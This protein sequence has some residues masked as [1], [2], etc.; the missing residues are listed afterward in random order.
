MKPL[1][2]DSSSFI[3][4][5]VGLSEIDQ[6]TIL[7]SLGHSDIHEF[8][9][10]V[11][12]ENILDGNSPSLSF[13]K[14]CSEI[15]ALE[16]ISLIAKKNKVF[17]SLI[18]LGYY[19][20]S[21]P[22]SVQRHV[23][24]NPSWYTA[25]TPYQAEI[26][27][28]RLE[29][30]FNFQTLISELTGLPIANASLL[31]EA[32]AAAE[33]MS[34]SFA[35]KKNKHARKFLVD[36]QIFPQTFSVLKTRAQ[37]LS[38][39]L[40]L[41]NSKDL[42]L[43]LDQDVF[44]ILLQLPGTNGCIWNPT[45]CIAKAHHFSALATIIIDPLAQVLLAP[46][47]EF[48]ADIAVGSAQRLGVPVGFGGPHAAFFA[49]KE[50][51]KRQVP[52]RLVGESLD[53]DGQPALRLALQ[54]REQHIRRDKATSNICTAQVLLA[55]LS[56]FFAIYHGSKGLENIAKKIFY[57]KNKLEH[58]LIELGY[59]V[60]PMDRFDTIEVLCD[61]AQEVHRLSQLEGFN[62]RILKSNELTNQINGFGITIDELSN[63]NEL[64]K[65][66][67]ILSK[68]KG[69]LYTNSDNYKFEK[70]NILNSIPLRNKPWLQQAVFNQYQSE[71]ELLRYIYRLI[72]KDF[73]LVNGMIPLG[74]CTMKLNATAELLPISWKEFYSIHPFAPESQTQGYKKL[75]TDLEQWLSDL[76]GFAASSL[77]PNAGSQGEFAGLL[78]IQAWHQS[79]GD[80]D[81]NVCLIP[82]SAHGTNPASAVMAGL[83]V[84]PVSCDEL[85]NIDFDDLAQKCQE[86]SDQLSS[87][88]VT[89]PSTHGVFEP[90]IREICKIVHKYGGQVY[91]DGANLNA[92]V[93]LCRPGKYGADVCHLNLHKTFC[94][95]HGGGGPGI[96]PIAVASHLAPF[97]PGHPLVDCGGK[98]AIGPVSSAPFGSASILPISW[99]YIRMMGPENLR[100]ASASAMLSA[101]F[102]ANR[103]SDYYPVLFK[104][105]NGFVAH[106]CILD[107]RPIK[108]SSGIEVDDI[109]KRLM[110]YGFHA[111]TVSWPV[112][113]TLMVEPTESESLNELNRFC[114][115][116]IAIRSE[117]E[118][119]EMGSSDI[120]NNPLRSAPHTL[121]VVTADKWDRPYSRT[122]AA[123]PL[124]HQRKNK[125]WPAVAR[126]DNAF[127]DRNLVCTC[128][129]LED[130]TQ[131]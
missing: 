97:L 105:I 46:V 22:A 90:Q 115:A 108:R 129:S 112:A 27:Q 66:K 78:V 7:Q 65:I 71:T 42:A 41:V 3:S 77:Q 9:A 94:I 56:A 13:E 62:F 79:R 5:H 16:E 70:K 35:V 74:S 33:A 68:A 100:K 17:R 116:M 80:A 1:G 73:S 99:M 119:I 55:V 125:F 12:P 85:G 36:D 30:L 83:R 34:L 58:F 37:P 117:I 88:M 11:V 51:F 18:G 4:R 10:S 20:T 19:G 101:N 60:K 53:A 96:G 29:A 124:N 47:S 6:G 121:N 110:D 103:L 107:L 57:L 32:T 54:T 93:G 114:D 64:E 45:E 87:L 122:Q 84:I 67:K 14:A 102:I 106:E 123:F 8:I 91:L 89:Y 113:G 81:R 86:H 26:S 95:P 59:P 63:E 24:E 44:G 69:N 98:K 25:Y 21:I 28:G 38:I 43:V 118:D 75:I 48:G 50:I 39:D 104:G 128:T 40:E 61:E 82:T 23:L 15:E 120:N 131:D 76:T 130:L 49:T 92:Q 52:G 111:P 2:T 126:I 109:A 127:G 31:D 72:S